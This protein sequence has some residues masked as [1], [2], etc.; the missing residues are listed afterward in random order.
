M[1]DFVGANSQQG[2]ALLVFFVSFTLASV[3]MLYG[4]NIVFLLLAAV[5]FAGSV[6][7]FLKA[8]PL[9]ESR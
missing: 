7:M 8:K 6:A 1:E 5:A 9:E 3:G 4:G 2:I